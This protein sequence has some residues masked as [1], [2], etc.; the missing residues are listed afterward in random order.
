MYY[1]YIR[2]QGHRTT[3]TLYATT[4]EAS[5]R[6]LSALQEVFRQ[7]SEARDRVDEKTQERLR[8][9]RQQRASG[10]VENSSQLDQKQL[11]LDELRREIHLMRLDLKYKEDRGQLYYKVEVGDVPPPIPERRYRTTT[12]STTENHK[13]DQPMSPV[14]ESLDN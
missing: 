12:L 5:D 11:Q 1:R 8:K 6:M 14:K 4:K 10:Q 2:W 3:S 7:E 9:L 13:E